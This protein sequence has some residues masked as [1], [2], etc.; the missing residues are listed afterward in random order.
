MNRFKKV[1]PFCTGGGFYGFIGELRNGQ[2]FIA[3]SDCH[4]VRIINVNPFEADDVFN[5][6][7]QEACLVK[8]LEDVLARAFF[9]GMLQF[10]I[11]TEPEGNYSMDEMKRMAEKLEGQHIKLK[12][13]SYK[14]V[15]IPI[16]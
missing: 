2:F 6:E 12:I 15:V 11:S 7:W 16:K 3:D 13:H 1:E 9:K 5:T 14:N 8:D 4:S 10:V